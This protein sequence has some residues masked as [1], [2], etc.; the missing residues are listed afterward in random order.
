MD[1]ETKTT[2]KMTIARALK[3]KERIS[4]RLAR[5]TELFMS[6]NCVRA[7]EPREVDAKEAYE[8]MQKIRRRHVAMKKAIAVANAGVSPILAEMLAVKAELAFYTNLGR[9]KE[10]EF[11]DTWVDDEDGEKVRKR[12]RI[13]YDSFINDKMRREIME[14]LTERIDDL[15]DEVD[16]FNATHFVELSVE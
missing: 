3:E 16:D 8:A 7:G 1:N 5:A 9:C 15:Q 14:K 12:E 11:V 13:V 10:V 4:R 6:V 2:K